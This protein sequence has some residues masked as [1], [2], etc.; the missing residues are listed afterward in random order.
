MTSAA[1]ALPTHA[2][3][4]EAYRRALSPTERVWIT[5]DALCPPFTNALVLEGRG[6]L[7]LA[8]W[9]SAVA[10]AADANPGARVVLR[11]ALGWSRWEDSGAAP[12]VRE[13]TTP[14]WDGRG[15]FGASFL[16]EPLPVRTGPTCAVW[17]VQGDPAYVVIRSHHATMDGRGTQHFALEILRALRGDALLGSPSTVTDLDLGRLGGQKRPHPPEDCIAPTGRH[18]GGRAETTWIRHSVALARPSQFLPRVAWILAREARRHA[19]PGGGE[20]RF[21]VPVDMRPR[22]GAVSGEP[23]RSTGNLTGWLNLRVADD[24]TPESL[25]RA[26]KSELARGRDGDVVVSIAG[27]RW[28]P[29]GLMRRFGAARTLENNRASRYGVSGILSNLGPMPLEGLSGAGFVADKAWLVPPSGH[30]TALFATFSG[31]AT[32][33]E[34]LASMPSPLASGGRLEALMATLDAEL[35]RT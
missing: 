35:T 32:G 24:A 21:D 15:P 19:G 13:V 3:A 7:D 30:A 9:T 8:A 26:M 34:V 10:A 16:R 17:L 27:L 4:R 25:A 11:G 6:Q 29:L 33:V 23:L 20:V 14:E 1:P 18:D 5:A 22:A 31:H 28:I 12:P 2:L